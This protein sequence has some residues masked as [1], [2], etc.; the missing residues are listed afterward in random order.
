MNS[1]TLTTYDRQSR[2]ASLIP[3]YLVKTTRNQ[4]ARKTPTKVESATNPVVTEETGEVNEEL[5]HFGPYAPILVRKFE[6]PS[7]Q[8]FGSQDSQQINVPMYGSL[9]PIYNIPK[10][11]NAMRLSYGIRPSHLVHPSYGIRPNYEIRPSYGIRPNYEIRPSYG[12]RPNGGYAH[13]YEPYGDDYERDLYGANYD[14]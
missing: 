1:Q 4:E 8:V 7:G 10:R 12:L 3:V 13:T 2:R 5:K 14:H 6:N 9:R 11:H